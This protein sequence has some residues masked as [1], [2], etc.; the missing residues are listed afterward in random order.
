MF[1]LQS[2]LRKKMK[3]YKKNHTHTHS[4]DKKYF[5]KKGRERH[6]TQ[7]CKHR[8]SRKISMKID[9]IGAFSQHS[10]FHQL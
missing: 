7:I 1:S 10:G 2:G 5:K 6:L 8:W 3:Y 9:E 4:K